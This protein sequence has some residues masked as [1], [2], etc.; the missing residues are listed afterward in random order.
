MPPELVGSPRRRGRAPTPP[1]GAHD[2]DFRCATA[3]FGTSGI[4]W[5]LAEL[6]AEELEPVTGAIA[7][8]RRLRALLHS[9]DVVRADHHDTPRWCTASWPQTGG[10]RSSRTC[11]SPPVRRR[12]RAASAW[13][14]VDP[15]ARY[16]VTAPDLAGGPGTQ[17]V[18]PPAW[19]A[20]G[21][22]TLSGQVLMTVGLQVPVLHPEQAL[23][24]HLLAG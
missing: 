14:G 23:V 17:Q 10:R 18:A 22:L 2:L 12:C 15:Q 20:A 6:T 9:G 8:Y 16:R 4:E 13:P 24:L 19:M 1:A 11:S 21:G 7:F 3:L 5:D